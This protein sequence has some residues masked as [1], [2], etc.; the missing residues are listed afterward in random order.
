LPTTQTNGHTNGHVNGHS[1]LTNGAN[2]HS[3]RQ[4][5]NGDGGLHTPEPEESREARASSG[6]VDLLVA[7]A[8]TGGTISGISKRMKKTW[9]G[10]HGTKVL[11]VDPVGSSLALPESLNVLKEGESSFYKVEGIGTFTLWFFVR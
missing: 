11:A 9:P 1:G 4:K 10:E 3:E 5:M 8:G 6:Q 2:G 7:G